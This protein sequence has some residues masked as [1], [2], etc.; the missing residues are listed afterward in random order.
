MPWYLRS[1]GDRDTHRGE[2]LNQD[3]TVTAACGIRFR[4]RPLPHGATALRGEPPEPRPDLPGVPPQCR[5]PVMRSGEELLVDLHGAVG[6][7]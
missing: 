3:G 4:P 1:I 6:D 5:C 2:L 7:R